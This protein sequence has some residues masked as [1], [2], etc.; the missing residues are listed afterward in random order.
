MVKFAFFFVLLLFIPNRTYAN[1]I[2]GH[3]FAKAFVGCG[4]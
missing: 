2:Y 1:K 3:L 4:F